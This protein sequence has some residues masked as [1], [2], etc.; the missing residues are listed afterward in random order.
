MTL[1]DL[2]PVDDN[3]DDIEAAWVREAAFGDPT[4]PGG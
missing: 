2:E 3:G 4:K 1:E